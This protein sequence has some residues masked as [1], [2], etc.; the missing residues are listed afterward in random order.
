MRYIL[1]IDQGTSSSRCVLYDQQANPIAVAQQAFTQHFPYPG[2]VEH[3]AEEI[4]ASQ[5]GVFQQ[6]MQD[7]QLRPDDIAGIGITNQ[8]ETTV[9]WERSTGK[10]IYNAIVWQD[11]R[12]A[13]DC[14][15]LKQAGAEA[16]VKAKTGLLLDA[17][18]SATKIS[19]L[20]DH[21]EG[22]RAQAERGELAFGTID[23]WL[24]W[25]L[26]NGE[27]HITDVSNAARTLLFNIDTMQWDDELLG[28]FGIPASLLPTVKSSSEIYGQTRN[29]EIGA[30]IPIAAIAGDQQAGL[31]GQLCINVGMA[32]CTYGTGSFLM[33]NT[34]SQRVAS[35]NGLL[36]T[37]AWQIGDQIHYAL[38]GGVF[39][40]GAVIQWLRDGLG[41]FEQ[42]ADSERLAASVDDNG[43]VYFVPALTGLGAPH[44]DPHARGSIFG[45][46]RGTTSAHITR[47]ALE[48]IC[49]QVD[50]VL[51]LL[52]AES[53]TAI[54][55]LR[56]DGG[57]SANNMLAQF[58]ADISAVDV[59]R[60]A[61]LETTAL[62][63]AY[64][65]GIAIG[66]WTIDELNQKWRIDRSFHETMP[67]LEVKLLKRY[68]LKAVERAKDW[69]E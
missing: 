24:V 27:L 68:W 11:R 45:I 3:D 49:F 46:T 23:S 4:W 25:K 62:G 43:G 59:V 2:W 32:K 19:W 40:G 29:Q 1:A 6:V 14:I 31:F 66:L 9:I 67:P 39:V 28:L 57:A 54:I 37:I 44:W 51:Q 36:T 22:A 47:A 34:G 58:Q 20:L 42:A 21:V 50:E 38:E 35:N 61:N 10:P 16:M 5:A 65:A 18:F 69:A 64:L 8:R 13:E 63:A 55:Q 7:A 41:L 30:G 15:R 26:T 53:G 60:P 17:Y 12:T 48:S 33:M 56:M 52:S